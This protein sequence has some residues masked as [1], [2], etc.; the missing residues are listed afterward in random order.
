MSFSMNSTEAKKNLKLER[1]FQKFELR[2]GATLL[3]SVVTAKSVSKAEVNPVYTPLP[4]AEA[5]KNKVRLENNKDKQSQ[6]EVMSTYRWA[7]FFDNYYSV[8]K[9]LSFSLENDKPKRNLL[10]RLKEMFDS[11]TL[12]VSIVYLCG[13]CNNKGGFLVESH[14][15]GV[16]ELHL[17]DV[18]AEWDKRVPGQVF[19]L[20]IADFNYSG[21]W[22]EE[23]KKTPER[24]Q[25]VGV[26]CSAGAAVKNSYC[27]LGT[28]FTHNVLK[29]FN[30][31]S[32]ET[33]VQVPA[34]PWL[35]GD[36]LM[37]KKYS[38][39]YPRFPNWA[40]MVNLQKAD[41]AVVDYDNGQF[42][43][44]MVGG[45]KKYWGCFTWKSG[46]F[47]DCLYMGEF[48]K[49]KPEGIGIMKYN[50]GRVYEG[51]FK[52][53]APEGKGTEYYANG[54]RYVGDFSKGFKSGAGTYYYKNGDVY[55]GQFSG[56]KPNG[57]GKLTMAKGAYYEG[58]FVNGKCQGQ[59][60]YRYENG[61]VYVGDWSSSIKHGEG[62]YKYANG[63]VYKGGF[64]NG[65]RQG[66]GKLT[67]PSGESYEGGW[68]NDMMHGEGKFVGADQTI[69][70]E[71][72]KG[73]QVSGNDFFKKDGTKK[74]PVKI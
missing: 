41:Y 27:E 34:V 53:S 43:G 60:E 31:I 72:V 61:D 56:N 19:L 65:M 15:A 10:I 64:V 4:D 28:Y 5:Q 49:G 36:L 18:L 44:H 74:L 25:Q 73:K 30:K 35:A 23:L 8:Y 38:N 14:Q 51:Q 12:D 17:A 32:S 71:W 16:E 45:Q 47:K 42:W 62:T 39:L 70:G 46:G 69:T 37:V 52:A 2:A 63:D 67:L 11:P 29:I 58:Q 33:L 20:V 21:K 57:K 68:E 6:Y 66:R 26:L 55:K 1:I 48:E 9:K 7:K 54:D 3:D 24:Y 22:G 13:P 59:G 40:E 50:N